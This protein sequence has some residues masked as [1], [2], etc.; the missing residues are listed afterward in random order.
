MNVKIAPSILSADFASLGR[1][2]KLL[3]K[4][5][6][7]ILHLDVMDGHFVPNLTFG[8]PLIKS[9]RNNTNLPLDVHLMVSN[10]V[11]YLDQ[12]KEIGIEYLSFH[13]E[14]VY[15]PHR[16]ISEIKESGI[17]A[18]VAVN[19]GSSLHLIEPL[20]GFVDYVL[21]MSVNPGFGGQSFITQ[22]YE[23]LIQLQQMLKGCTNKNVIEIEVDGGISDKNSKK[24]VSLGVNI[25][26]AGS[27]VLG[28]D[29]YGSAIRSL[30]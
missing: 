15:H 20:L 1:E 4:G 3:E 10:P 17:K 18:G 30:R 26:V 6:A 8:Y 28:S 12:L 27:Y 9:V 25:L 19:P 7:D 5:G 29:D 16:F 11:D 23:K 14:T 22:T 24:L 21:L 2:L 13:A